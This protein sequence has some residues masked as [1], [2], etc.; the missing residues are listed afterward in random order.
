MQ[1][2]KDESIIEETK[3]YIQRADEIEL[4][5]IAPEI[6]LYITNK[7]LIFEP[8]NKEVNI[9]FS[10]IMLCKLIDPPA[11]FSDVEKVIE[12][13]Y[14]TEKGKNAHI[15]FYASPK[16]GMSIFSI[17]R[18]VDKMQKGTINLYNT[19]NHVLNRTKIE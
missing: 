17:S 4:G 15:V 5:L 19:L 18:S 9:P 8:Q 10:K 3:I 14:L 1:L 7:A 12:L 6:S 16:L 13:K 2:K 11:L